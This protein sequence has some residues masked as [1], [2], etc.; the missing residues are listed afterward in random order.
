M[1]RWVGRV[2]GAAVNKWRDGLV[3]MK[4]LERLLLRFVKRHLSI[5]FQ[6][7]TGRVLIIDQRKA[8][9][10]RLHRCQRRVLRHFYSV[11]VWMALQ[12]WKQLCYQMRAQDGSP[13]SRGSWILQICE[14][15]LLHKVGR[16]LTTWASSTMWLRNLEKV[17]MRLRRRREAI[18]FGTWSGERFRMERRRDV[19]RRGLKAQRRWLRRLRHFSAQKGLADLDGPR[20]QWKRNG[21]D[22]RRHPQHPPQISEEVGPSEGRKSSVYMGLFN[23]FLCAIYIGS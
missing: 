6:T 21:Q 11:A 1:K 7:W 9:A 18:A 14:R 23:M 20:L 8:A 13:R 17:V 3:F 22:A 10:K 5:A 4:H 19:L 12:N 16:Y 15:W 2:K